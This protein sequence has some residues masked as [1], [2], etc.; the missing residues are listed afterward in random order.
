[1]KKTLFAALLVVTPMVATAQTATGNIS[2][3]ATVGSVVVFS[4]PVALDF[5]PAIAPG[6]SATVL[7]GAG[8]GR[9]QLDYNVAPTVTAPA[10]VTLT[11]AGGATMSM[12][13]LC[14]S[15][16]VS[17]G[18]TLVTFVCTTPAAPPFANAAT[19]HWFFVG[20]SLTVPA[21]QAAGVYTGTVVL[22]AAFTNF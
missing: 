7:P 15:D 17:T 6:S 16:V 13:T 11:N 18:A 21:A 19:Q 4:N 2:A 20:G 12:S 10:S 5:G 14:G 8:S 3:T 1:M 9:I 22:T